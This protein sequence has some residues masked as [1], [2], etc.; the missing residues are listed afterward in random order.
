MAQTAIEI[1]PPITTA[2]TA[3]PNSPPVVPAGAGGPTFLTTANFQAI[4]RNLASRGKLCRP[5]PA[6]LPFVGP[7]DR[8]DDANGATFR[9]Q[10]QLLAIKWCQVRL[11]GIG[12]EVRHRQNTH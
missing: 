11:K 9:Q 4:L 12:I 7:E 2:P 8:R 6:G 1:H 10:P 3:I 5:G